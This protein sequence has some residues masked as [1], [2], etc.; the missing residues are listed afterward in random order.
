MI[1]GMPAG[2]TLILEQISRSTFATVGKGHASSSSPSAAASLAFSRPFHGV[3]PAQF[4]HFCI[5]VV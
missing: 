3:R 2:G 1:S 5:S 4:P